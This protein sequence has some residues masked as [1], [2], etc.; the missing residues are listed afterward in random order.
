M[1]EWMSPEGG[2]EMKGMHADELKEDNGWIEKNGGRKLEG[3]I[4]VT[5]IIYNIHALYTEVIRVH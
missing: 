4:D 2:R 3:D 5:Y 1:L